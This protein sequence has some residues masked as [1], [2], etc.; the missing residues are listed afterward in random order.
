LGVS[1]GVKVKPPIGIIISLFVVIVGVVIVTVIVVIFL[2]AVNFGS[3]IFVL[4][5]IVALLDRLRGLL[6]FLFWCF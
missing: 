1:G 6:A 4:V 3:F 2:I 5:L